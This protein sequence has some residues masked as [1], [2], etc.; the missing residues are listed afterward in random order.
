MSIRVNLLEDVGQEAVSPRR[1]ELLLV[2]SAIAA[3]AGV[4]WFLYS[5]Q[6]MQANALTTDL[7]RMESEL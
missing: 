6:T 7:A 2:G 3:T 4:I 1:P 5:A